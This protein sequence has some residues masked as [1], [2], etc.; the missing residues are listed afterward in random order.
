MRLFPN[1]IEIV[2]P[3]DEV[4]LYRDEVENPLIEIPSEVKGLGAVRNWVLKRF[5]EETVIMVDDD[6]L[7]MYSL[8]GPKSRSIKDP[9]EV[10]QVLINTAVMAKDM[11]VSF[12]GFSQTD[13]RKYN[14]TEPFILNSW[15]GCVVGCVG[16]KYW[17]RQDPFK[18]DID[19]TLQCLLNDR[20]LL[21]DNRYHF[22]Q[23]RDNNVGGCSIFRTDEAFEKSIETL[24]TKWEPYI[25]V[26]GKQ[27]KGQLKVQMNIP[28]RQHI[29]Y[30]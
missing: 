5:D 30:E 9:D 19:M 18:V 22:G 14:S 2:V 16:R 26:G 25:S 7:K 17:F 10:I 29:A 12:F 28:R 3:D 15:V 8:T 11:G 27:F 24:V 13:I 23:N 4:D 6:I 21:M 1:W 20:I